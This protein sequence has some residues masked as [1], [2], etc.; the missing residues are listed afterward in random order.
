MTNP[1]KI[2][3]VEG[4][5]RC[6]LQWEEREPVFNYFC[7]APM[8]MSLKEWHI[9]YAI[10]AAK[11][12][13]DKTFYEEAKVPY[14]FG[15]FIGA[16]GYG[17]GGARSLFSAMQPWS[18][19]PINQGAK[20]FGFRNGTTQAQI[21]MFAPH[22]GYIFGGIKGFATILSEV[23]KDG[24]NMILR[25]LDEYRGASWYSYLATREGFSPHDMF[26]YIKIKET[27]DEPFVPPFPTYTL[28]HRTKVAADIEPAHGTRLAAGQIV[29]IRAIP[30]TGRQLT[31]FKVDTTE[32]L[33][34]AIKTYADLAFLPAADRARYPSGLG[35]TNYGPVSADVY[36]DA[37][38][39]AVEIEETIVAGIPQTIQ[40]YTT[41][42]FDGTWSLGDSDLPASV[43]KSIDSTG[44]ITLFYPEDVYDGNPGGTFY[45]DVLFEGFSQTIWKRLIIQILDIPAYG[46]V[47]SELTNLGAGGVNGLIEDT[48]GDLYVVTA[49]KVFKSTDGIIFS[50]VTMTGTKVGN[51]GDIAITAN[52]NLFVSDLTG[53]WKKTP[54]ESGFTRLSETF[55]NYW[56]IGLVRLG[57]D[58]LSNELIV[59]HTSGTGFNPLVTVFNTETMSKIVNGVKLGLGGGTTTNISRKPTRYDSD[60]WILNGAKNGSTTLGTYK[61]STQTVTETLLTNPLVGVYMPEVGKA[62]AAVQIPASSNSKILEST[63]GGASW[64]QA[65]ASVALGNTGEKFLLKLK[66]GYA[67]HFDGKNIKRTTNNWSSLSTIVTL[68][69]AINCVLAAESRVLYLGTASGKVYRSTT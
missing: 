23:Y 4:W 5:F 10:N 35:E 51:F 28:Y 8:F 33:P 13:H 7:A 67:L 45:L 27:P 38:A 6:F 20:F 1:W 15:T 19:P 47:W 42:C 17:N 43:T 50:E 54:A 53:L 3:Y 57:A 56:S 32:L 44:L 29:N 60:T 58:S 65:I 30:N 62:W 40:M 9:G 55:S 36:V 66:Q 49:S 25:T 14:P 11:K 26:L 18:L 39:D 34:D 64:T 52:G 61:H 63:D 41:D 12:A 16:R 21:N 2:Q 69:S 59:L 24:E 46:T 37:I 48:N 68:P 22:G 31:S